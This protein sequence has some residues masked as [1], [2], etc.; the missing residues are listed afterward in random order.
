MAAWYPTNHPHTRQQTTQRQGRPDR[1]HGYV[2]SEMSKIG[3]S[4]SHQR[5]KDGLASQILGRADCAWRAK[6]S[7]KA[8]P[9]PRRPKRRCLHCSAP[10]SSQERRCANKHTCER[11]QRGC[12]EDRARARSHVHN[13]RQ[14]WRGPERREN[15]PE[16]TGEINEQADSDEKSKLAATVVRG[17][18]ESQQAQRQGRGHACTCEGRHLSVVAEQHAMSC[19]TD[20]RQEK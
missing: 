7:S 15:R 2:A 11:K 16:R 12:T 18:G 13:S 10:S 20:K 6:W 4:R 3:F 17:S 9:Q 14:K 8:R 19:C 1:D 5:G